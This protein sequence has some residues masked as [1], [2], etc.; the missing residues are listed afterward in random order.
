MT[1][2]STKAFFVIF[3]LMPLSFT[4]IGQTTDYKKIIL[5]VSAQDV[6]IEERLVQL[7]WQNN[8][9]ANMSQKSYDIAHY[10]VSVAKWSWLDYLAAQG[11][12][13]EFTIQGNDNGQGFF[14]R[15]NFSLSFTLGALAKTPLEVKTAKKERSIASDEINLLKLELRSEVLKSYETYKL[16]KEIYDIQTLATEDIYSNFLLTEERFKNGEESLARYNEMLSK[17]NQQKI[18][19]LNAEYDYKVARL[20]LEQLIGLSLNEVL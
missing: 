7:A 19:S 18:T 20:N 8:P 3:S 5:P 6:S 10:G 9:R 2:M 4:L 11:N 16:T 1:Q 13:N 14:P 15:Y 17:Y 12:L